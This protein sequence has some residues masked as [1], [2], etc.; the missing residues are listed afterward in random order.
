MGF[1]PLTKQEA[2]TINSWQISPV[3][4]CGIYILKGRLIE[5]DGLYKIILR[6]KTPTQL[7]FVLLGGSL[8]QRFSRL[9]TNVVVKVYNP[10]LIEDRSNPSVYVK[11][12][13]QYEPEVPD[14]EIK[15]KKACKLSG[16]F[17]TPR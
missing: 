6:E 12:Y 13:L 3:F 14:Y 15:E 9:N 4:P 2:K 16:E 8:D 10:A 17:V 7:E 5:S 11:E 1:S